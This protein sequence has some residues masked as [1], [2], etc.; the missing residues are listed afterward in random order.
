MVKVRIELLV[1]VGASTTGTV[2][3][4]EMN[5]GLTYIGFCCI[6]VNRVDLRFYFSLQLFL[7][8]AVV[9]DANR[10]ELVIGMDGV[11]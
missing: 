8:G 4:D 1:L 5:F 10:I 3:Q 6:D 7:A 11:T 9:Q 2:W